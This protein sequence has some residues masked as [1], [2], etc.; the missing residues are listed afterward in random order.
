[1]KST[2]RF[3]A[4]LLALV[5][6]CL[7]TA[8]GG[9]SGA[10]DDGIIRIGQ[11]QDVLTLYPQNNNTV[12]T[13]NITRMIYD[14]LLRI[15]ENGDYKP[16]LAESWSWLDDTTCQFILRQGIKFHNGNDFTAE[17]VAYTI[18]VMSESGHAMDKVAM[19]TEVEIV[20][21]YT[22]NLH[23]TGA[24]GSLLSSLTHFSAGILD[25]EHCEKLLSE[26]K[27]LDDEP[28]GTGPYCFDYWNVGSDCQLLKN[29]NYYNAE[30]AA[31]NAGLRFV[32]YPETSS[33]VIALESGDLDVLLQVPL[34]NIEDLSANPDVKL[35]DY[36]STHLTYLSMNSGEDSQLADVRV[37]QAIAYAIN[38]DNL[39]DVVCE[40]H[41]VPNYTAVGAG[42]NNWTD[43]NNKYE[44]NVEKAKELLAEC[45]I[46]SMDILVYCYPNLDTA[47]TVL[48]DNLREVGINVEIMA[49]DDAQILGAVAEGA[50][51]CAM[52]I[53]F[54]N[55]E[56]DNTM[57]PNFHSEN[58]ATGAMNWVNYPDA[59]M[60]ELIDTAAALGDWD[61]RMA[62]YEE[63]NNYIADNVYWIPLYTETGYVAMGANVDGI[64]IAS[65]ANHLYQGITK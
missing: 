6:I 64:G 32:Y 47:A 40:G 46:E 43:V 45:G 9:G 29:E 3:V 4:M 19:I 63:L 33:A 25:K 11:N 39:I 26:G 55:D 59:K 50:Y 14:N 41:A 42:A 56:P 12:A 36:N 49:V 10:T 24:N 30:N 15:D 1:M 48:Q 13:G 5:M 7:M 62:V 35:I 38:R 51:D 60:D 8:C 54:A 53:W 61:E 31:Q 44:Y 28:N 57:R 65:S 52:G 27:T 22:V 34:T 20:D 2:K 58:Y 37:R 16:M 23:T 18:Q 21:D 17:D